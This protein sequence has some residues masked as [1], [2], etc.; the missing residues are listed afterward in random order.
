M[1]KG[2]VIFTVD[3]DDRAQF[4]EYVQNATPTVMQHGGRPIIVD[5]N[6]EV[7]EGQWHGNA[8]GRAGV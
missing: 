6:P 5:D 8:H 1:P 3:V 2:Y 7:V 4:D